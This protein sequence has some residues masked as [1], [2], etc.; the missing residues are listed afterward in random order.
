MIDALH[1]QLLAD[2]DTAEQEHI[3][4]FNLARRLLAA[5]HPSRPIREIKL[6]HMYGEVVQLLVWA[7]DRSYPPG[8][9]PGS[10]LASWAALLD[11]VVKPE[12]LSQAYG[13]ET[14]H[15]YADGMLDGVRLHVWE[16]WAVPI[17]D[18]VVTPVRK[19]RRIT[20]QQG[21]NTFTYEV[22]DQA[23]A[24][25][26]IQDNVRAVTPAADPSSVAAPVTA[27]AIVSNSRGWSVTYRQNGVRSSLPMT[28]REAAQQWVAEHVPVAVPA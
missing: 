14:L 10:A 4:A 1:A 22:A 28:S 3:A 2:L 12:A 5:P 21:G 17:T 26:W 7:A 20:Y 6:T 25:E 24:E 18:V 11:T 9:K 13:A 15:H 8:C 23:A 16:A 27:A 19:R